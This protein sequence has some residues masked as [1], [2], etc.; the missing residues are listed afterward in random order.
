MLRGHSSTVIFYKFLIGLW[1]NGTFRILHDFSAVVNTARREYAGIPEHRKEAMHRVAIIVFLIFSS[2]VVEGST[3]TSLKEVWK[4]LNGNASLWVGSNFCNASDFVGVTCDGALNPIKIELLYQQRPPGFLSPLL[5]NITTLQSLSISSSNLAGPIPSSVGQLINLNTLILNGG[6]GRLNGSIPQ[7]ICTLKQLTVL[8]LS[9][10]QLTGPIPSCIGNLTQLTKLQLYANPLSGPIP[11]SIGKTNLTTI[12]L[13]FNRLLWG[14][15]PDSIGDLRFLQSIYIEQN[16]LNQSIPDS[17]CRLQSLRDLDLSQNVIPG[18]LPS[19]IGNMN[20]LSVLL[21]NQNRMTGSLPASLGDLKNIFSLNLGGNLFNGTIPDTLC[22]LQRISNVEMSGC[23]LIGSIPSC[24]SN[25]SSLSTLTLSDNSLNG[26]IPSQLPLLNYLYLSG[27]HLTGVIPASICNMGQF[28]N[29]IDLS[30]NLL[31]GPIPSCIGNLGT[32]V[33]LDLSVNHLNGSIPSLAGFNSLSTFNLNNNSLSGSIPN[34][35]CNTKL[36]IMHLSGNQLT[37]GIPPCLGKMAYLSDVNLSGNW[38]NGSIPSFDRS[39]SLRQLALNNNRLSGVIPDGICNVTNVMNLYLNDNDLY[40]PIPPCMESYGGIE[41]LNLSNNRI[42]GTLINMSSR[43]IA[44]IDLSGNQLT[45]PFS[46][47]GTLSTL[48]TLDLS[49]N[50]LSGSIVLD[51]FNYLYTLNVSHNQLTGVLS[52]TYSYYLSIVDLSDNRLTGIVPANLVSS[53]GLQT[54][55]I[56]HNQFNG[57]LPARKGYFAY[58][59]QTLDISY[60]NFTSVENFPVSGSCDY[61]GNPFPC[62]PI[63]PVYGQCIIQYLP[64]T[65]NTELQYLYDGN[66][67]LTPDQAKVFLDLRLKNDRGTEAVQL[68][69]AILLALLRNTSSFIYNASDVSIHLQ[70][71]TGQGIIYN[72]IVDGQISATLPS[73]ITASNR[74]SVA[75]TS[76]SFNP[77]SSVYNATISVTGVSVYDDGGKEMDINGVSQYINISMGTLHS[78]PDDHYAVC[79]Y[80]NE[81]SLLWSRDGLR[82]VVDGNL[83]ICQTTHLTNFSIGIEYG[84]RPVTADGLR[85]TEGDDKRNLIIII[86]CCAAGGL[87]LVSAIALIIIYRRRSARRNFHVQDETMEMEEKVEW[88]EMIAQGEATQVWRAVHNGTTTVAVKKVQDM[89][90]LVEEA[91]RLKPLLFS[92]SHPVSPLIFQIGRDVARAMTYVAEQNL[93][94]LH[95]TEDSVTAKVTNFS[96]CVTD[97]AKYRKKAAGHTAPEVRESGIQRKAADVW[98]YGLLLSFIASDGKNAE[99]QSYQRESRKRVST[100]N[101][102]RDWEATVKSLVQECTD[103]DVSARPDFVAIAKRMTREEVLS[104]KKQARPT[105]ALDPYRMR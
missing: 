21:L 56:S 1:L 96:A 71:Y 72:E 101:V 99:S 49:S 86:V 28:A 14:G 64:C 24:I 91:T 67:R 7:F 74:V 41:I 54:L 20:S 39:I 2:V 92:L 51:G 33:N 84:T 13:S 73:S 19:C 100:V 55:N 58:P 43:S 88:V 34:E 77:F 40:G 50:R 85:S 82:T 32:L 47:L 78:I 36:S 8:D 68:T 48:R 59:V 94:L 11:S 12:N 22:R 5:G 10:N 70:T 30:S 79:Q 23:Q 95:V 53:F 76:L 15:L 75:L 63:L 27:N 45:G 80:W 46:L 37:G 62:L 4:A 52:Q 89:R 44:Q 16:G 104:S 31:T 29:T 93:V 60:N 57:T 18:S 90:K 42:N 38:L 81:T 9:G 6:G 97:G 105:S 26:T 87:L 65:L 61:S 102:E 17:I 103:T 69:S 35:I 98:S 25:M 83:T 3:L 66:T